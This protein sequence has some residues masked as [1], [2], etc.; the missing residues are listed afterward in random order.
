MFRCFQTY[1]GAALL[2]AVTAIALYLIFWHGAHVAGAAPVLL[3]LACPLMHVFGHGGHHGH[4]Q[5]QHHPQHESSDTPKGPS[6]A[7]NVQ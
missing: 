5:H 7:R 2:A 3:L 4:G 1:K 6:E